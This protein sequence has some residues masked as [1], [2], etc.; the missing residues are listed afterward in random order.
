MTVADL[1]RQARL[2]LDRLEPE[3]AADALRS[4]ELLV[5][6]RPL[7]QRLV[8]GVIPGT[9]AI[10]RNVLEWRLDPTSPHRIEA[11][12]GH[13][14]RVILICDE[15]Y[16]SSLAAAV[17]RLIGLHRATDVVGGFQSWA[18][19]GLPVIPFRAG[20]HQSPDL[21]TAPARRPG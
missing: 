18:R 5:D 9:W 14:Q 11:I 2:G 10:D 8:D 15:G 19:R 6:I 12:D 7:T 16:A 3:A 21:D 17:L 20:A 4:G 13:D 1:L